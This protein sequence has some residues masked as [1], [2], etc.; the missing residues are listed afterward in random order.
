MESLLSDFHLVRIGNLASLTFC[1]GWS[2][3]QVDDLAM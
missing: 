1:N 3:Q 2:E